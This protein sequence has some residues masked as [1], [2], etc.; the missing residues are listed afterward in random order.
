[1]RW[2]EEN[3]HSKRVRSYL[4]HAKNEKANVYSFKKSLQMFN[5][6]LTFNFFVKGQANWKQIMNAFKH[7][8]VHSS[9]FCY[10]KQVN[11]IKIEWRHFSVFSDDKTY[12]E[13]IFCVTCLYGNQY[14][15]A[16]HF[17]KTCNVP[18]PFCK[19]C[20][21]HH[22]MEKISRNHELCD[23]IKN[24]STLLRTLMSK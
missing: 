17:C 14:N 7:S 16:T 15:K 2:N 11:F 22:T 13:D 19:D 5:S 18:E 4:L 9:F 10:L 3:Q 23:D 21:L 20:A 24:V 12:Q 1:M 6:F 8:S